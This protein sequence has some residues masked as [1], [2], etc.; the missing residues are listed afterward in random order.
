[1]KYAVIALALMTLMQ[2][3]SVAAQ[4]PTAAEGQFANL[5]S[6]QL[7][8][9]DT[10]GSGVPVVLLHA[11]TGSV[12]AW[13]KQVPAFTARGF[14]V[15]SYDRL[16][17]GR[18][19]LAADAAAGTAAD[20]LQALA[21]HLGIARFHLVGTAAGGIVALDY[22]VSFPD[23]VRSLVVANS[24]GGVQ[25]DD[26]L[27]LGRRLRPSPQFE[28][29][30]PEF[31]E[32]GPSYRAGDP[33]GTTRW[34]EIEHASRPQVPGTAVQPNRNRMTFALLESLRTPTLLITGGADLYSPPPIMRMFAAR[35]RGAETVVFPEAGHSSYWEDAEGFNRAVLA[36]LERH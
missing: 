2:A 5:G 6:R 1:M 19:K 21:A 15:I 14:R 29:L 26:Y 28:A 18:S 13:E 7:W 22:A 25:D 16:G 11:R 9:R 33:A 3:G 4:Q 27:A 23:R 12:L 8:Y 17:S 32:V 30:P 36:F 20:D 34:I 35:I 31:R 24:I 10:G